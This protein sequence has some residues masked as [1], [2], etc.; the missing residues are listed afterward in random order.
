MDERGDRAVRV[1]LE[2]VL[3]A[4]VVR[5]ATLY[6]LEGGVRKRSYLVSAGD[7]Q[8]VL[9]LPAPG[10]DAL[11]DLATEADVMRAAAT[12]GLA[13][14]VV[15]VDVPAGILLTSYRAAARPWTPAD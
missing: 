9:R 14:D 12:A 7:R 15:A 11:L 3:R 10:A 5:R 6:G 8:W 2:R 1:A 13:P 4:D